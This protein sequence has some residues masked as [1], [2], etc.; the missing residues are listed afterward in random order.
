MDIVTVLVIGDPHFKISNI[1]ETDS[2]VESIIRIATER[3]PDMIVV[4]GDIL[5]RHETIHVS[6]LTRSIKFLSRL[7]IIAPTYVLIGNHDLKNNKQFLSD[8]HPFTALKLLPSITIVDTTKLIRVKGHIFVLVPYTPPGRFKEALNTVQSGIPNIPNLQ[9]TST[10][11]W[12]G[13]TC[14]FAHQEFRGAQMGAM[15]STEGDVWPTSLP[16]VV[17]GHIH[18]Y[19]ELQS[20]ILYVG[21]PIQHTYGDRHDKTISLFTYHSPNSRDHERI[22][23]GLPRKQIV[24]LTC[25]EISSYT[26]P[27][28]SNTKIVVRGTTGELKAI[29]KHPNIEALKHTN[30]KIVYKDVP[31]SKV[32]NNEPVITKAPPKF[33]IALHDAVQSHPRLTTLYAEIFGKSNIIGQQPQ[34]HS[35]N[36]IR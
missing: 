5:D 8:E 13:A 20:N 23:L 28:N 29:M 16:Y 12:Q 6:P 22:D 30:N 11:S 27:A 7:M 32:N 1:C 10:N 18:D 31:L 15:T 2:M 36:I 26:A 4:L 33:S 3:H 14:I 35:L 25:E 34:M 21:T 17:S 19:Q 24:H 9:S